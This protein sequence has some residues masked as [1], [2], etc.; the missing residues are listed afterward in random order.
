MFKEKLRVQVNLRETLMQRG[1]AGGRSHSWRT[2]WAESEVKNPQS[3]FRVVWYASLTKLVASLL[4]HGP[5]K[6]M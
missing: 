6:A 1:K 2:V 5:S 4:S 3:R